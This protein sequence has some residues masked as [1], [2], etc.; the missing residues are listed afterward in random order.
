MEEKYSMTKDEILTRLSEAIYMYDSILYNRGTKE[1]ILSNVQ[2]LGDD[3]FSIIHI[4]RKEWG[5]EE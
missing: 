5:M 1:E 2:G 4:L 3:L